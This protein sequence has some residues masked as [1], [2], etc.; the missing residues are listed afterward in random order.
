MS[1]RIKKVEYLGDYKLRLYFSD[2]VV[3]NVD[4]EQFLSGAKNLL[5]PLL[6]KEF[7]KKVKCDGTT[8]VW[9]NGVDLCPDVLYDMG[10]SENIK[11]Q[12]QAK[13]SIQR[14]KVKLKTTD[15]K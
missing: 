3:K 1:V 7:F 13:V 4:L 15:Q 9:P 2:K 11:K 6:D 8:V 12:N 10:I 14:R 5:L